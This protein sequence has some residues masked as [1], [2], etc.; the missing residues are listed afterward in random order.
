MRCR[1]DVAKGGENIGF[2]PPLF[3]ILKRLSYKLMVTITHL[4]VKKLVSFILK[5]FCVAYVLQIL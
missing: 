2:Y 1:H 3:L 5:K 4:I